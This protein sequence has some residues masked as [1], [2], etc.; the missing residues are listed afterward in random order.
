MNAEYSHRLL[1]RMFLSDVA[2]SESIFLAGLNMSEI[3]LDL[4]QRAQQ[5]FSCNQHLRLIN[6]MT[7]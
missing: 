7:F 2:F 4:M 1:P 6:M 5:S 3:R